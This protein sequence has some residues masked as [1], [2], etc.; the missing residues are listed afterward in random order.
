MKGAST[1]K[2][3]TTLHFHADRH[4]CRNGEVTLNTRSLHHGHDG[5]LSEGGVVRVETVAITR[6]VLDAHRVPPDLEQ[7][8][9]L[10]RRPVAARFTPYEGH[11]EVATNLIRGVAT[12]GAGG[13]IFIEYR[14]MNDEHSNTLEVPLTR[15]DMAS[16]GELAK[17]IHDK[18]I[19]VKG[20]EVMFPTG[21]ATR[22]R[23]GAFDSKPDGKPYYGYQTGS[24]DFA[25][26][27]AFPLRV[28]LKF[29]SAETDT[30]TSY[31][32][33]VVPA[34]E[35]EEGGD[36]MQV[37][38][39]TSEK[40]QVSE[41]SKVMSQTLIGDTIIVHTTGGDTVLIS[42][43]GNQASKETAYQKQSNESKGLEKD[44]PLQPAES[45]D[46]ALMS[47][48]NTFALSRTSGSG[49]GGRG[50]YTNAL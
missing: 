36:D 26:A 44:T 7:V 41:K 20:L 18:V 30:A 25:A 47:R 6:P 46:N 4:N 5:G 50:F 8:I 38:E 16:T 22:F 19:H 48:E 15:E 11:Q 31:E 29:T 49:G 13:K 21:D 17:A 39:A 24:A 32:V 3:I 14:D 27:S 42:D 37:V 1:P 23:D 45:L 9:E 43:E 34:E 12:Q 40:S 33:I 2:T 28:A 35:T 10:G